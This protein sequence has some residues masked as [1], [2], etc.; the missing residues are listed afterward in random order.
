MRDYISI[1]ILLVTMLFVSCSEKLPLSALEI[2]MENQ[3]ELFRGET[4]K[5]SPT[6][7]PQDYQVEF[8]FSTS[9]ESVAT[10]SSDGVI[11]A[12][13][14]GEA[15]I[16]AYADDIFAS[17]S[18]TIKELPAEGA[19]FTVSDVAIKINEELELDLSV[20]PDGYPTDKIKWVS[21]DK[22]V[23]EVDENGKVVAKGIG[24]TVIAA[25]IGDISARCSLSVVPS[26]GDYYYSDGSCYPE[27]LTE[28]TVV[29]VV[30][31]VGDPTLE[32]K[33]LKRDHPDCVN[34]LVMAISGDGA[35]SWQSKFEDY[36]NTIS[37]WVSK[38][39]PEYEVPSVSV[40]KDDNDFMNKIKGYNNTK[41][42]EKFNSASENSS[43]MC[44]FMSILDALRSNVPAPE[45]SSGWYVPSVKEMSLMISGDVEDIRDI[46]AD[47]PK[48]DIRDFL[49]EKLLAAEGVHICTDCLYW[50]SSEN[51]YF[52]SYCIDTYSG[53]AFRM[54]KA[55]YTGPGVIGPGAIVRPVL[56]F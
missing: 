53:R 17:C 8:V 56:A 23:A 34:G 40:T 30:F 2:S 1:T 46:T 12:V 11:T 52:L 50:S 25:V 48:T 7:L 20:S 37:D 54:N 38:Y 55:N 27:L 22:S 43:W 31:W 3:L 26:V 19:E 33:A 29:G 21:F 51:S 28:K 49:N 36:G 16:T 9:D 32:D 18:V 47:S 6:V 15:V 44:D 35:T 4:H 14:D 10:V 42:I 39:A 24:R 5:L 45:T 41:A 13:S